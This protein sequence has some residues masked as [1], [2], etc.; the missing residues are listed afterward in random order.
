MDKRIH[1]AITKALLL[2]T[3]EGLK[4]KI[5]DTKARQ[6]DHFGNPLDKRGVKDRENELVVM[7]KNLHH[8]ELKLKLLS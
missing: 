1:E 8:Y 3:I 6:A 4:A 5:L 2:N 7:K